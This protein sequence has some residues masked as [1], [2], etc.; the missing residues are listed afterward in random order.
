MTVKGRTYFVFSVLFD[1]QIIFMYGEGLAISCILYNKKKN[2]SE[3]SIKVGQVEG[4]SRVSLVLL[5]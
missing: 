4:Q 5:K 3:H 1:N 2:L